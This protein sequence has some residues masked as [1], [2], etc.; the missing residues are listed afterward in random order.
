MNKIITSKILVAYSQCK[1][2]AFLLLCTDAQ[3]TP[4]EYVRILEEKQRDN[5]NKHINTLKQN[6]A[7]V[8]PYTEH[9]LKNHSDFLFDA[10]LATEGL[11]AQCAILSKAEISSSSGE[12]S[13]EPTIFAGTHSIS[14]EQKLELLFVGYVLGHTQNKPPEVGRIVGMDGRS[15]K[16]KLKGITKALIPFLEN[17]REWITDSALEPPPVILN[18][19]CPYCQ[20]QNLCRTKAEQENNLSLLSGVTPKMIRGFEKKGIFTVKQLSYLFKPRK[21]KKRAKPRVTHKPELQALAIRTGKIYLQELPQLSRQPTELF[22]DIEGIPDQQNYYL[23]GLL[24]CEADKFTQ[25]SF[26]AD[27]AQDEPRIWQ[28]FLDKVNQYPDAPVYHYGNYDS[29][30]I[31]KLA[32]RYATHVDGLKKRAIN[33]NAHI[34]GKVYFPVSSNGLKDI[35]GFIG[36]TWT[37]SIASGLQSLVWR[38]HWE[39]SQDTHYREL[40]ITYNGE[41]CQALRLLVD[42]LSKIK[43][44][45]DKLSD[46]DFIDDPKQQST[47]AGE[48][49]HSQFKAI[50]KSAHANYDKKKIHF[51]QKKGDAEEELPKEKGLGPKTGYQGQ[52]K[53]RPQATSVISVRQREFCPEHRNQPLELTE[54]ISKELTIDL[55]LT[56]SGIR[57]TITEYVGPQG[58]CTKCYKYYPPEEIHKWAG[59]RLYGHGFKAFVVYQRVA[60]HMSYH[61][62]AEVMAE[63]FSEKGADSELSTFTKDVGRYYAEAEPV[64]LKKLLESPFIH[65]DETPINI[66]GVTEYVWVFTDGKNVIFKLRQTREATI[67]HELLSNYKGFLISDFYPGYDSVQCKQQKCWVHLIRDLNDDLWAN[68]YDVEYETFVLEIRNL[69]VPIMETVQKYG[70]KKQYLDEFKTQVEGFYA[71]VITDKRYK[72]EL[73]LKYQK[74]FLRY[75]ESL[76]AF[77]GEDG[78][79]WHNNTAERG[80][81]HIAKQQQIS[82]IFHEAVTHD[83]LLLL[84]IRQTCR[85]Q[86]KSFLKFLF[87]GKKNI[88]EFS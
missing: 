20:F 72:S 57:K 59:L 68:P 4:H 7:D 81:R 52:R 9:N 41:D 82:M 17:L 33:V 88:D 19:H 31:D 66:C 38:H 10:T 46:V 61:G 64:I 29:R 16:I 42:E 54:R 85:F 60:L 70:S 5:Q 73:A 43:H 3:G 78:I 22:L 69:I 67:V 11:E 76:F 45:A 79:P 65:I 50:L 8:Q 86:G 35:G 49:V 58:Y 23:I 27:T 36:A 2:K 48:E 21:R 77:L 47:S 84:G 63:Q 30:A 87:S 55:V 13:Y 26:W 74:R 18:K 34:Y 37:S 83:Y 14:K 6:G 80:L 25:Y 15:H 1:R 28:E 12:H 44:S 32:R 53:V 40:L 51:R 71:K 56:E 39:T 62:I 75:R 24:V